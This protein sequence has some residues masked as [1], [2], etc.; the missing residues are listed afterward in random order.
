MGFCECIRE[1]V[2]C[3]AANVSTNSIGTFYNAAFGV[4]YQERIEQWAKDTYPDVWK[5]LDGQGI[6]ED[7]MGMRQIQRVNRRLRA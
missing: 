2:V 7:E 4:N 6:A 1:S 3:Y 5:Q